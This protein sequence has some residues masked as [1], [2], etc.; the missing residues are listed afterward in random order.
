MSTTVTPGICGGS[1]SHWRLVR[2]VIS[3]PPRQPDAFP[4][5][6]YQRSAPP[7]VQGNGQS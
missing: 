5:Y 4:R 6:R 1:S 2:Y 7:I 3:A